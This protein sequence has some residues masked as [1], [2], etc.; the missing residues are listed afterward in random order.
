MKHTWPVLSVDTCVGIQTSLRGPG[1]SGIATPVQI[2]SY[3]QNHWV[4]KIPL[5]NYLSLSC[6]PEL[7]WTGWLK[8]QTFISLKLGI[9]CCHSWV[10]GGGLLSVCPHE[11][12]PVMGSVEKWRRVKWT[13]MYTFYKYRG[14]LLCFEYVNLIFLEVPSELKSDFLYRVGK[15]TF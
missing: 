11:A 4:Y 13:E 9:P 6:Y 15:S 14:K 10:L 12:F 2:L 1:V 5:S 3:Q 8:Q 7:P